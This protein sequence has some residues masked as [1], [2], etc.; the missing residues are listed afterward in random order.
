M[1]RFARSAATLLFAG[2]ASTA[3]AQQDV[4]GDPTHHKTEFENDCVRVVRAI[5]GPHEKSDG[6]FD[7]KSV[8]IVTLSDGLGFKVIF[9]DGKS[10]EPPAQQSGHVGWA[11]APP[12]AR[13]GLENTGDSRIE[14]LVIEPKPGC[15]N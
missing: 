14:Y 5:F 15:I 6:M 10:V 4:V 2:A 12:G 13:I 11:P 1:T 8:V 7:I 3:L 9:P